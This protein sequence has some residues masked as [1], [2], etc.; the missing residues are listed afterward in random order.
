QTA[1]AEVLQV[2]NSSPGD[3]A[4][5]FDAMLERALTLCEA[6]FGML[7]TYD[8]DRFHMA[9]HRGLS[10]ELEEGLRRSAGGWF[11]GMSEQRLDQARPGEGSGL[12]RILDGE[13]IWQLD[14][15]AA[16]PLESGIGLRAALVQLGGVRTQLLV[17]LRK[18]NVLLGVFH[19]YR[20]EVRPFTDK[21]IALLRNFAAQAVI[22]MENARLLTE[23]REGVE[24]QT[25]TAEVLGVINSSPRDLAPVFDA[26]LEKAHTLCGA[27]HGSLQLYDGETL[28][29][30]ATQGVEAAFADIL[31]YGYIGAD[32]PAS[33]SLIAGD[34][35]FQIVDCAKVDHPVFRSASELAGIGT[36]LFV[37]LRKEDTFLG[38][39]SAARREVKPFSEKQIT[40]LQGFASQAV[41]A[42]DNARLLN[43][44]RQR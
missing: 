38:L 13:P 21:Q 29:A 24:Q 18:H 14:D 12:R 4:P 27:A 30:V 35:F 28:R 8:G 34:P 42:M 44:I 31:R 15:A 26:I 11:V 25:A 19:V 33:G 17:A 6:A 43:E 32:S 7:W 22:A 39:I 20:R 41:I 9:A 1:T 3:L 2:I 5:V 37:P 40:I 23:T 16:E 36:V 10:A